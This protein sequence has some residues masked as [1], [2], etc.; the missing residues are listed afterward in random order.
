MRNAEGRKA[1]IAVRP[2]SKLALQLMA[3]LKKE[4]Y[5]ADYSS[6]NDGRGGVIKIKLFGQINNISVIKPRYSVKIGEYEKF[7][8]RYLPA[9]G[10]G[11]L[12]ISTPKGVMT[13]LEAKEK[14]LG[15]VLLAY[16][17]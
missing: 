5:I 9:K 7:E 14:K 11:R 15:G 12:I 10:F 6:E 4:G 17:Y 16:V 8:Q 13:H 3:L 1:E 2:V